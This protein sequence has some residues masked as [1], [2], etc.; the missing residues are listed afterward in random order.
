MRKTCLLYLFLLVGTVAAAQTPLNVM[1][2]NI[3]YN[4]PGDSLDAWPYRRDKVASTVLFHE[5]Q[6]LGMQ[7][8]LY[9]QVTDLQERLP[10]YKHIGVGRDDGK[11]KGEFS[12]IFYDTTR[13]QLLQSQTFWLSTTPDVPGSKGWD[14]A[15]TRV[16]TWG[17]FRDKKTKQVFI[18]FNTHFDHRG[19]VARRESAHL[20]LKQ[21]AAIAGKT[22]AVIT[23]DFNATPTDEPIQVI[24]NNSDPLHLTDS[25]AVSKTPHF[26]PDGTF[27]GFKNAERGDEPIDY[28]FL[29]G[30]FSVLQHA[31]LSN[32]WKGHFASDH[33]AV[34]SRMIVK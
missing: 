20:L 17:K 11:T 5:A 18:H 29:K 25:K 7:E 9:D 21:V 34:F 19:T 27:N 14:A 22:P 12:A 30:N 10:Q 4:N 16:V 2:F 6:L 13:L 8:A 33:F 3:R 28:I 15:I 32:T 31:S 1:T 24:T 23:G 26:G